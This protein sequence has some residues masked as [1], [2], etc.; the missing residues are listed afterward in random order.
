MDPIIQ[1]STK[2]VATL[3]NLFKRD[4]LIPEFEVLSEG[5]CYIE[6]TGYFGGVKKKLLI[7]ADREQITP[8]NIMDYVIYSSGYLP[9]E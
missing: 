3:G 8:F 9:L 2:I 6:S 4:R 1:D 5:D 7:R